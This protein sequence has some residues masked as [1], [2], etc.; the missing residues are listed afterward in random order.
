MNFRVKLVRTLIDKKPYGPKK[1]F[2]IEAL[3]NLISKSIEKEP[4][5]YRRIKY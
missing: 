3:I 4:G 1:G 5:S 2:S